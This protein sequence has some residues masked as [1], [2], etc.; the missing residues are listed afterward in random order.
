MTAPLVTLTL[1]DRR[2]DVTLSR[3]EA[4]NALNLAMCEQLIAA[5]ETIAAQPG[6]AVVVLSSEGPVFC[7]GADLKERQGKDE[8]WI[9]ARR[10]TAFRAYEAIGACAVPVICLVQ[11][12][13]VGSG[14]EIAMSCDFIL[15]SSEA[16]FRFPEPQWGTVGATQRLQ[17]AIGVSR[18]KELLYTGRVMTAEEALALGLVARL[19]PPDQLAEVAE[20]VVAQ[21]LAAP[22]LAMR[23]TKLCVDQGSRTDLASGIAIELSA[24]ERNLEQ[25]DWRGG[26]ARFA[27]LVGSGRT[28][29]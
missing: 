10:R 3:P 15:A 4:R 6:I 28:E 25:S 21:V 17:R 23:L 9:M 24:I 22:A 16:T 18:A 7:A 11:G 8:A 1:S 20:T 19:A 5:F 2:A 29:G 13:L 14:G 27:G 12:P 26:V